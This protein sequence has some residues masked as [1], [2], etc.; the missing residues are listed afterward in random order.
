MLFLKKVEDCAYLY[1]SALV[2][3]LQ[4]Q[5][6][7]LFMELLWGNQQILDLPAHSWIKDYP[8]YRDMHCSAPSHQGTL[9]WVVDTCW[10]AA[11]S[12]CWKPSR[13]TFSSCSKSAELWSPASFAEGLVSACKIGSNHTKTQWDYWDFPSD[14]FWAVRCRCAFP[15]WTF[16]S[17]LLERF[18]DVSE[19]LLCFRLIL[20]VW[21]KSNQ[22]KR[23]KNE[24]E[25][26]GK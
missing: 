25:K 22:S 6:L 24:E 23:Q 8:I 5:G 11:S 18:S 14:W 9:I 21:E 20:R 1:L 16:H 26:K 19:C 4:L 7:V 2:W 10:S 17:M 15:V 3:V 12:L 13:I